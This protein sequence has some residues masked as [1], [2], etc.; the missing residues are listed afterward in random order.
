[1]LL[2]YLKIF[3]IIMRKK[4]YVIVNKVENLKT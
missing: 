1:M 3:L 2:M 4:L